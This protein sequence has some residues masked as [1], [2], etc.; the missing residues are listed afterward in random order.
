TA[1]I[2]AKDEKGVDHIYSL[3]L[4]MDIKDINNTLVK[5]PD[6][7]GKKVTYSKEGFEFD[8]KYI[9]K[10]KNDIVMEKDNSFEK[11]GERFVDITYIENVNLK[12][13]Y[14]EIYK[15]NYKAETIRSFDFYS[16]YDESPYHFSVIQY[17]DNDGIKKKGVI[18]RESIQN[19]SI[20]FDAEID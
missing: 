16:N 3:E 8:D 13:K 12:G 18:H 4:S 11:V 9:G 20:S 17:T 7:E 10:Y 2:S 6:L 14:Y 15:E 19:I 1:N 5:A